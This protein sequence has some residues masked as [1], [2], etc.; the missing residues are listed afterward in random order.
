M[1]RSRG[2]SVVRVVVRGALLISAFSLALSFVALAYGQA[3]PAKA[4]ESA[5]TVGPSASDTADPAIRATKTANTTPEITLDPASLVPDLPP[6]PAANATLIGGTIEHIDPVQDEITIRVFGGGK[7]KALF[8]PRTNVSQDGKPGSIETLKTGQRIYAD[9]ILLNGS[10]FARNIRLSGSS[11]I[12][13]SQGVVVSYQGD[14]RVLVLRD[15]LSP[16]P[17]N[18]RLTPGTQITRGDRTASISDL[19]PGTLV[20]VNFLADPGNRPVVRQVTIL[21]TPGTEFSFRGRVAAL[22]LH[23]GLMVITA[24][25]RKMYEIHFNPATLPVSPD[26][27]EGA[28]VTVLTR[29]D[30]N[31]YVARGVTVDKEQQN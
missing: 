4:V 26:L 17:M 10:V 5:A 25:D 28:Q 9:T 24:V 8:D 11:P 12:G 30:G 19:V 7:M 22:D 27:R 21:I 14:K 1:N 13:Q 15:L 20:S 3:T 6:L 16:A 2:S 29:Y 31:Q 23:V 18:L